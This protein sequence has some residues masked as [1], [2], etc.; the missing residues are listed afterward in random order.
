MKSE[1]RAQG[2]QAFTLPA[3]AMCW[4]DGIPFRLMR[5]TQIECHPDNWPLIER[6][7]A[8]PVFCVDRFGVAIGR[9]MCDSGVAGKEQA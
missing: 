1:Q 3:G 4:R 2:L 7:P 5:A 9:P 8:E 6:G